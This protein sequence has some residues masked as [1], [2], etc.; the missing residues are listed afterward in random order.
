[1]PSDQLVVGEGRLP[2][3]TAVTF[4]VA[5]PELDAL[6]DNGPQEK[7]DASR[8]L[9]EAVSDPDAIFEGLKQPDEDA[10]LYY[11]VFLTHDP[12]D[13]D[14]EARTP[15]RYGFVFVAF[16][17]LANMGYV[18]FDW[19]WREQDPEH[20]GHPVNWASDFGARVWSRP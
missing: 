11:S 16:V 9:P 19:E 2:D 6:R 4:Y 3:G 10:S 17:R 18:V 12:D 13:E 7:Y 15:P 8:F 5:K 14:T 20:V 1:M